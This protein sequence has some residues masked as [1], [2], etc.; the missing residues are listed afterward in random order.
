MLNRGCIILVHIDGCPLEPLTIERDKPR[1]KLLEQVFENTT[2][3]GVK[4]FT[5]MA[6]NQMR[7]SVGLG[8]MARSLAEAF[9]VSRDAVE[10]LYAMT[11]DI[12]LAAVQARKG[13]QAL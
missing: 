3:S 2:A 12:G 4:Y 1:E 5:R 6:L 7:L 9:D 13:E 10:H 11:N 8:T